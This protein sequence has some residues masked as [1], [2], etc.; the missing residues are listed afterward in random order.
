MA[1]TTSTLSNNL[2]S[3]YQK[4]LLEA[5]EKK[6]KLRQFADEK[7]HPK[8]MGTDYFMLKYGHIADDDDSTLTESVTPTAATIDNTKY[9]VSILS[10]GKHLPYSDLLVYT[11]ID[12]VIETFSKELGYH[13]A[14]KIDS[15]IR[16]NWTSNATTNLQYVGTG[17]TTDDN[18]SSTETFTAQDVINAVALLKGQDAPELSDGGYAW[19]V[20]PYIA[21]DIMADT[22]AGGFQELNKYVAG[23]AEKPLKGEVGKVYGARVIETSNITSVDNASNVGV[24][25]TF[26][27]AKNA[28]VMTKFNADAVEIITKQPTEGGIANPLNLVGSVGYK[29]RFGLKYTGG[30]FSDSNG[31][32]PDLCIQVRGTSTQG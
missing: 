8:G 10:Y 6:L 12:P 19:V 20:H 5:A 16:N 31:S 27:L 30:T 26:V 3:F 7:I 32:S 18:I 1:E 22:S 9:T 14:K 2:H 13:A 21:M 15:L 28:I 23:L 29:M 25:R 24:Y 4:T 11:A 17:N